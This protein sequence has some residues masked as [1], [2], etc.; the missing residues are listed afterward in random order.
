[1][2]KKNTTQ[3]S[4]ART[5]SGRRYQTT[6]GADTPA[7][8]KPGMWSQFKAAMSTVKTKLS[9]AMMKSPEFKAV[10]KQVSAESDNTTKLIKDWYA[11]HFCYGSTCPVTIP[12][13]L[14]Q[15]YNNAN[16]MIQKYLTEQTKKY[17]DMLDKLEKDAIAAAETKSAQQRKD[18]EEKQTKAAVQL[19]A[20]SPSARA[21]AAAPKLPTPVSPITIPTQTVTSTIQSSAA[22]RESP[23]LVTGP[24]STSSA[25]IPEPTIQG[26]WQLQ[27]RRRKT[28]KPKW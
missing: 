18:L 24:T 12:E 8:D 2:S 19:A 16:P 6:G 20:K 7:T 4:H 28:R 27:Q 11:H 25:S 14:Q 13:K 1:M 15:Q 23:A 26:G 17:G 5:R 21:A 10:H 9:D 22:E 3:H